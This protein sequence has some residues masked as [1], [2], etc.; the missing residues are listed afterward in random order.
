MAHYTPSPSI[1]LGDIHPDRAQIINRITRYVLSLTITKETVAQVIDNM[2]T[3][4]NYIGS[5][6]TTL[7][8]HPD[9][10]TRSQPSDEAM[11]SASEIC[12]STDL[13]VYNVDARVS[14]IT[15]I[16]TFKL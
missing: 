15:Y 5:E 4:G 7:T 9:I 12:A 6:S 8:A 14:D 16:E 1:K 3:K 10:E 13:M 2:P 11:L